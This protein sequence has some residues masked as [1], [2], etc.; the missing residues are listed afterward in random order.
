MELRSEG[1][2]GLQNQVGLI[3]D[4]T[5][6]PAESK[7]RMDVLSGQLLRT[8]VDQH[9]TAAGVHGAQNSLALFG[10]QSGIEDVSVH[11]MDTHFSSLVC[12]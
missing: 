2:G 9:L 11:T 3:N 7:S 6:A 4:D 12:L 5:S 10:P 1:I 8:Q